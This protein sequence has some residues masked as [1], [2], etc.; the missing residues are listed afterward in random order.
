[1][2]MLTH[3]VQYCSDNECLISCCTFTLVVPYLIFECVLVSLLTES[4]DEERGE[5]KKDLPTS[6]HSESDPRSRG[7]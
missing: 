6:H 2:L 1:M 4:G 3:N 5:E 7:S